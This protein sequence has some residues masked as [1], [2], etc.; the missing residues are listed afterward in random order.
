MSTPS[1]LSA[2]P[3]FL[4]IV[5]ASAALGS[6]TC[7]AA[8][9][10]QEDFS[11]GNTALNGTTPDVGSATWVAGTGFKE[12][13]A[14]TGVTGGTLGQSAWLPYIF[15][16]GNIYEASLTISLTPA[17][18]TSWFAL[19]FTVRDPL[20]TSPMS[21]TDLAGPGAMG[22]ALLRQNGNWIA[23]N[24]EGTN[25]QT[26][27]I[28]G[29]GSSSPSP[30]GTS[31][32]NAT[33]RLVLDTRGSNYVLDLYINNVH[34]DLTGT[35]LSYTFASNTAP[36]KGVGIGSSTNDLGTFEQFTFSTIA[37]P[38]PSSIALL[39]LGGVAAVVGLRRMRRA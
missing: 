32:S 6:A 30:F 24:G 12:N 1:F 31:V 25:P 4:S 16:S 38:E 23:F 20:L 26:V 17:A 29:S 5:A 39:A 36:F 35:G 22:W 18:S 21:G 11:G 33:I 37:I 3:K 15:E 10:Y 7:S 14:Y 2:F 13:G 34:L 9:I 8:L 19:G 28:G 27:G